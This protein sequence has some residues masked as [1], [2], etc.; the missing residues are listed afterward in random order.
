M[1]CIIQPQKSARNMAIGCNAITA[2]AEL[3]VY[4]YVDIRWLMLSWC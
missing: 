3:L 1:L 2:T 4:D